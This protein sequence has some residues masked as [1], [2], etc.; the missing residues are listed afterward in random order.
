MS[1][2]QPFINFDDYEAAPLQEDLNM[3]EEYEQEE[4]IYNG[5]NQNY[6]QQ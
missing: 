2:N 6:Y 5:Q 1:P 3:H 4:D